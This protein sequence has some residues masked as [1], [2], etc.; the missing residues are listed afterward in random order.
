MKTIRYE[1]KLEKSVKIILA[2]L[3]VEILLNAF[4]STI[5]MELFGFKPTWA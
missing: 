2:T 3:A 5:A 4:S 1:V